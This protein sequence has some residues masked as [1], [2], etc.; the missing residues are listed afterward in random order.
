MARLGATFL[1]VFLS[2]LA[3][4]FWLAVCR[5]IPPLREHFGL[6]YAIAVGSAFL[7]LLQLLL[8]YGGP[9]FTDV[10][11][12]TIAAAIVLGQYSHEVNS[13]RSASAL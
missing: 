13:I 12:Y 2:W 9:R 1:V 5:V 7:Y 6:C 4:S 3:A 10:A 11:G 8:P